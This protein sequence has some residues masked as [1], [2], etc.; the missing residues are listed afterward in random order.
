MLRVIREAARASA[1]AQPRLPDHV[2][3]SGLSGIGVHVGMLVHNRRYCTLEAAM[4]V[5]CKGMAND[6]L[7]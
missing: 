1:I 2:T 5:V 6:G 7:H 4:A 3:T